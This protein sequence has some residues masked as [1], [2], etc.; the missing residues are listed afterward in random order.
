MDRRVTA[1][2]PTASGED[3]TDLLILG[4]G[5]CGLAAAD[6]AASQGMS[7]VIVECAPTVGGMLRTDESEGF[8]FDRGGHRFITALP[9]VLERVRERCPGLQV[10]ERKSFVLLDGTR[11]DYPLQLGNL[12]RELPLRQHSRAV[13]SYLWQRCRIPRPDH[14]L[15][16]WLVTR[17]GR[18]LY[19]RVFEGYSQKLWGKHPRQLSAEWAPQR[20]SIPDLGGFLRELM[21]PRTRPP[22]TYARNYLYPR[23]GIGDIPRGF[24]RS[25]CGSGS[26]LR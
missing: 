22:R 5:I 18:Y 8:R 21:F 3:M 1:H 4:G 26:T 7:T 11:I 6:E 10:R 14:N 20:I 19:R 24:A 17:F 25:A 15:E 13:L 9:W 16:D 2:D 23:H 12:L